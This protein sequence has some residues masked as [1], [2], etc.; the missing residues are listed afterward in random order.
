MIVVPCKRVKNWTTQAL[1]Y[2]L[3]KHQS[4]LFV[5]IKTTSKGKRCCTTRLLFSRH[6]V[7]IVLQHYM[8]HI[9]VSS[10]YMHAV[11]SYDSCILQDVAD[12]KVQTSKY[13]YN[14]LTEANSRLL[15]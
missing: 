7:C 5:V 14:L 13:N 3:L 2:I 8:H 1:C 6:S 11:L 12:L 4:I 10:L 9:I 15:L